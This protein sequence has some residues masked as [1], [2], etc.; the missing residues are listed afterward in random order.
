MPPHFEKE[1]MEAAQ[2]ERRA[3]GGGG[4]GAESLRRRFRKDLDLSASYS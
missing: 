2:G 3:V 4:G 1:I